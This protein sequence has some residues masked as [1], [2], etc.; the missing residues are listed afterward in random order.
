MSQ[1]GIRAYWEKNYCFSWISPI[2]HLHID[3]Q[4]WII[5]Y[6]VEETKQW[7]TY[8]FALRGQVDDGGGTVL[9]V[10]GVFVILQ[11][12]LLPIYQINFKSHKHSF[13]FSSQKWRLVL[14]LWYVIYLPPSQP[15]TP[16]IPYPTFLFQ[17]PRLSPVCVSW[18]R[19]TAWQTYQGRAL[20]LL[21]IEHFTL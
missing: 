14:H 9:S 7:A 11:Q 6:V 12:T 10:Q 2:I 13:F 19:K 4:E 15:L 8:Q 21:C 16:D 20:F 5:H 3:H 18:E 17:T 1:E